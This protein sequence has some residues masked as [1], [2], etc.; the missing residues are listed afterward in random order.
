MS[1]LDTINLMANDYVDDNNKKLIDLTFEAT[2]LARTMRESARKW[3]GGPGVREYFV[4]A[5]SGGGG[6]R[7]G[8][9]FTNRERQNEQQFRWEPR[10][11]QVPIVVNLFD[12]RVLNA[13]QP[14]KIL[15]LLKSKIS[16][17][18]LTMGS[19]MEIAMFLPG[20]GATW[21]DNVN[22]FAEICSQGT[23][24]DASFDGVKYDTYGELS[25]SDV[26]WGRKIRGNVLA[27]NNEIGYDTLE[28]T[29]TRCTVGGAEPNI[30]YTTPRVKSALKM[31]FQ[32]QQR[33]NE[34]VEPTLGF[35]GLR[36][37]RAIII[38]S[39]YCPGSETSSD[40][41][42]DDYALY[43]TEEATTPAAGYPTLTT[44]QET[45]W[46]FNTSDDYLHYYIST[47]RIYGMGLQDFGGSVEH[48]MLVARVRLAYMLASAGPRYHYQI[49]SI[50]VPA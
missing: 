14:Y 15:D 24:G 28:T 27:L 3:A 30:G 4:Y 35:V 39:R 21:A 25:R 10:E 11:M 45:F 1:A 9:R 43:T 16:N 7:P 26:N 49:N 23:I 40:D 2:R 17:A 36:F 41:I 13:N 38:E 29:Y 48:D 20:S 18:Y 42:A 31:K 12:L 6:H 8:R 33:F 34:V 22:G 44:D 32:A 5:G 19:Y 50:K 37:N 46:W 47:D